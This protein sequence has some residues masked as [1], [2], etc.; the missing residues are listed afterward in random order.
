VHVLKK[1][2]SSDDEAPQGLENA[3]VVTKYKLAAEM[4]N[5]KSLQNMRFPSPG[6]REAEP[7]RYALL[8][9]SSLLPLPLL[10]LSSSSSL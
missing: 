10:L 6:E 9:P 5:S 1:M 3:D 2:P 7:G 4:A 8:P